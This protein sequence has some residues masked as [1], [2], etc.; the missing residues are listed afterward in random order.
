MSDKRKYAERRQYLINAVSKRRKTIRE[1]AVKYKGGKC[2][3]CGYDKCI[4]ALE[5][6]H[7]SKD[8]EFSI[9][10][11]GLTRSWKRVKKEIQKCILL[12]ANCHREVHNGIT[13]LFVEKR[14][15][16][17]RDNGEAPSVNSGQ[18]LEFIKR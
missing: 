18:G 16:K 6:H 14:I 5:F 12:C 8:K 4:D 11:D 2:S 7:L 3:I 13:Q 15:E 17:S 1:M 9:S 10:K